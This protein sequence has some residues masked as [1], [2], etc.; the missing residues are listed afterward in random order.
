MAIV[1][2]LAEIFCYA[3]RSFG[4][5]LAT[6]GAGADE[7]AAGVAFWRLGRFGAAVFSVG[8]RL[9]HFAHLFARACAGSVGHHKAA[10]AS[11]VVLAGRHV[12]EAGPALAGVR[13]LAAGARG[14]FGTVVLARSARIGFFFATASRLQ[15][16]PFRD[17]KVAAGANAQKR[18]G[19]IFT[20]SIA[21]A[22]DIVLLRLLAFV[23]QFFA[24]ATRFGLD[25]GRKIQKARFAGAQER[26]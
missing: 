15:V 12:T 2:R 17:V 16:E 9:L 8:A 22:V 25:V 14:V 7:T 23:H 18:V 3:R 24:N 26:L 19:S 21:V 5:P 11:R 13:A 10:V 6:R 20:A 4:R 1:G